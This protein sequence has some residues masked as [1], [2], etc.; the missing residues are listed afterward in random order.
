MPLFI[1]L[2]S[3]LSVNCAN[4][5][6][7]ITLLTDIHRLSHQ[8]LVVRISKRITRK[9][10]NLSRL[11][12]RRRNFLITGSESYKANSRLWINEEKKCSKN[13]LQS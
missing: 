12:S 1:A 3:S 6:R 5:S 13:N 2:L 9:Q 8:D 11:C 4:V 10:G 7:D